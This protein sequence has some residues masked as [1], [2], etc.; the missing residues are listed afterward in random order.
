MSIKKMVNEHGQKYF[1]VKAKVTE[2][3]E[4]KCPGRKH[5]FYNYPA[6][7]FVPQPPEVITSNCAVCVQGICTIA[8]PEE[9]VIASHTFAGTEAVQDYLLDYLMSNAKNTEEIAKLGMERLKKK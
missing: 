3:P 7:N 4:T 1:E 6:Q 2:N 9:A 5:I 8:F